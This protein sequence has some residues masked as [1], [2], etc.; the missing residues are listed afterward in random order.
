MTLFT[1]KDIRCAVPDSHV[2]N[3]CREVFSGLSLHLGAHEIVDLIGP[4]GAGKSM[5]LS[6]LARLN[7]Y[8]RASMSL[9][10][11]DSGELTVQQWRRQ[12]LYLPQRPTLVG[13]NVLDAVKFP[14]TL[15]ISRGQASSRGPSANLPTQV[16]VLN[17]L[18][19][20]GLQDVELDRPVNDLSVGQQARICLL[21]SILVRPQVLLCDEVDASLDDESAGL[22][23]RMLLQS[24]ADGMAVLRVRH[25]ESDGMAS[26]T[27]YLAHGILAECPGNEVETKNESTAFRRTQDAKAIRAGWANIRNS[28]SSMGE[29]G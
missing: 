5:L 3:G 2:Q 19:A 20:L 14:F 10:G 23:S 12:V 24:T 8:G 4:S 25:H 9:E 6:T 22:V 13:K 29:R 1:A 26:R 27:L 21:R 28:V 11:K 16:D 7:P 18:E 17:G 15:A